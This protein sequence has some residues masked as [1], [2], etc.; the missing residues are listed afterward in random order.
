VAEQE[1]F[2]P[3]AR[4]ASEEIIAMA[5]NAEPSHGPSS[6]LPLTSTHW[7]TYRVEVVDGE[8]VRLHDFEHDPDPSPIGNGI[9][10]VVDGPTRISGPMV[11]KSWLE[12]GPGSDNH[13]RGKEPFVAV[14]WDRAEEL[15]ATELERVKAE[16]GSQAIYGGSYGWSSAGR[17]HH[18]QGQ[19]HRFLNTIGG[20]T[21]SVNTYSFAAAEVMVPHVIGHFRAF[22]YD[23]PTW[24]EIAANTE[25]VVAFGGIPVK[26]GQISQGGLGRH[27]QRAGVRD[28]A[29]AGV[30]FVNVSPL[31]SDM[32]GDAAADWLAVR[33][34]TDVAVM[35]ALAHTLLIN[36]L[37]DQ[38]FLASHTTGFEV[39]ADYLLGADDGIPK[40]A[41]WAGTIADVDPAA[42]TDLALRMARSRTIVSTSWSLSRHDHGEQP[43]WAGLALAS[44]L[45]GIGLPGQGFVFGLSAVN[46]VGG[47]GM[48]LP[49]AALPQG[50]NEV[51]AFVPV[52]RVA[53]ALLHPNTEFTYDGQHRTYP[54]IKL[55]WWSGG[56][57]FHHHQ[58]L[59]RLVRA[60]QQPDTIIANEWTWNAN[61]RHADIV[62]A[63]TTSLERDD[64]QVTPREA[65]LSVMNKVIEPVGD[66]R[67]DYAIFSG[68]AA[69]LGAE[70]RFTEG[71]SAKQWI[72]HLYE[73][74]R[75]NCQSIGVAL[76]TFDELKQTQWHE[77]VTPRPPNPWQ[78]F[79]NGE[80][81]GTP[82]GKIEIFS[83][84]VA[85]FDLDDCGGHPRWITPREWL[86]AAR[87]D[88]PTG[89]A[90]GEVVYPLHLISN[91]PRTKL[92]SQ[93]DHGSVSRA[94]KIE[95]REPV[96][97]HPDAAR[98]R[99][100]VDGQT[101]R[102]FNGRGSVLAAVTT[103]DALRT[104]VVQL[105]T[106]AW[107]DPV[108]VD[109][110]TWCKHGNPN[111]LTK[112][113]GTSGL[114]QGPSA[115]SCLVEIEAYVGP[116]LPVTA[117]EPP[118]I[119]R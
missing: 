36:D 39:F 45:G 46:G 97:M 119:L 85:A 55:V 103:D 1:G 7:G 17:F 57:P 114:A 35:L 60:W 104:D 44:M 28:A 49:V 10:D 101:V 22:L 98:S 115:H 67:D 4:P 47:D 93:L 81:L 75:S 43:Y 14:S 74:T 111:V 40:T 52:A 42:I 70:A 68:I 80:P 26:N 11:R 24:P 100:L 88:S 112:D 69:R 61:A 91:Q 64:V 32:I 106:G 117:F 63:S 87:S 72:E 27:V 113:V 83:E 13:L 5:V 31:R 73:E 99:N 110:V 90:D 3:W 12:N 107:F 37:H 30:S 33:P 79:R 23:G 89:S 25:L 77:V 116:D 41:A 71:R 50:R 102:I 54:D 15:V 38:D 109:G 105:S 58:D 62:L 20:Y 84:T 94:A 95:G 2:Y 51:D 92:H 108:E 59:S 29:A 118:E 48:I 65:F 6:P 19:L 78:R 16:Y 34:N 9:V 82:S 66:A 86:G 56:N 8:V 21:R 53:D 76:P 96:A 18:A